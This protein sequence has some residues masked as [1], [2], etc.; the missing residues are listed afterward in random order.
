ML[1]DRAR[2]LPSGH[3]LHART[4][5]DQC[6]VQ[7]LPNACPLENQIVVV[8]LRFLP[9]PRRAGDQC[10]VQFLP[11]AF[12]LKAKSITCRAVWQ[13]FQHVSRFGMSVCPMDPGNMGRKMQKRHV[14]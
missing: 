7:S 1:R 12:P 10:I 11:H 13:T 9:N 4:N 5:G 2:V 3:T 6:V 14:I 8:A